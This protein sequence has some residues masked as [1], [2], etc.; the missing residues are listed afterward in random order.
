[1]TRALVVAVALL[2]LMPAVAGAHAV[3]QS[4]EP[5]RGAALERAPDSVSVRFDEPVEAAF[6]AVRVFAADGERVDD[7][8]VS[9]PGGDAR[10]VAIGLRADLPDGG[11]TATYRVVSVDGHP[12]TGGFAFQVG[13]G[14]GGPGASVEELL[15]GASASPVTGTAYGADR[16]LG[17]AAMAVAVGGLLFLVACWLPALGA[18]AGA[19]R[20]AFARRWRTV[21]TAAVA[22]G[23]VTAAL[24]LV[25]QAAIAGGTSFWAAADPSAVSEVAGT[26]AGRGWLLRLLAWGLLLATVALARRRPGRAATGAVGAAAAF[27]V[28]TPALAGHASVQ[29]PV[30]LLLPADVAHVAAMC[31]WVGGLVALLVVVP[32]GTRALAPGARAGLLAAVVRRFSTLAL[33][34]V[35]VLAATGLSAARSWP[36]SRCSSC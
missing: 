36:R 31:A 11:Y 26:R 24:G 15:D 34:S 23:L 22:V 16:A 6:G 4:T 32:A 35:V 21:F 19:A 27:L 30:A 18:E 14:G 9:H 8:E 33:W 3:V 10:Q 13:A 12:V 1:V 29:S 17:Y 28:V 7:G 25:F 2:A 5:A 20:A